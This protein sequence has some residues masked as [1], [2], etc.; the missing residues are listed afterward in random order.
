MAK[1]ADRVGCASCGAICDRDEGALSPFSRRPMCRDCT[2]ELPGKIAEARAALDDVD[3]R[4][5]GYFAA[6]PKTGMVQSGG[7]G[8][9]PNLIYVGFLRYETLKD[10]AL[11]VWITDAG[12][13]YV[14]EKSGVVA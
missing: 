3:L 10:G 6:Y 1:G 13:A 7:P 4:V 5:L 2:E 12:L 11:M 8:R 9:L 14:I